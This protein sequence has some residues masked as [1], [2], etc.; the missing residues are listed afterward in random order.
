MLLTRKSASGAQAVNPIARAAAAL[1]TKT[2]DRRAF[3]K[4]S[5]L[6]AGAAA[7]ASQLPLNMIGEAKAQQATGKTEIRK[8][9]CTHCSVGCSVSAIVV[10][11]V[12]VRQ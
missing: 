4:G 10:D 2:V 8:T 3:L 6:A 9:V 12:W 7:F 11:G 5:G 1:G